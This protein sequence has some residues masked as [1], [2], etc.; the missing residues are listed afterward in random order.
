[1]K[2]ETIELAQV[3]ELAAAYDSALC[4][5]LSGIALTDAKDIDPADLTEAWLFSEE[6]CVHIW[7]EDGGWRCARISDSEHAARKDET[8]ALEPEFG[9]TLTVRY[10]IDFDE[11]GQAFIAC[12]RPLRREVN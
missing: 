3:K 2:A 11:D 7:A 5:H 6:A 10:L 9:R 1:M 8:Y 12:S 4:Y